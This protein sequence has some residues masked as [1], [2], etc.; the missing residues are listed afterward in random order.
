M[1]LLTEC[2]ALVLQP[3]LLYVTVYPVLMYTFN[4]YCSATL[5]A[6][7]DFCFQ[8][9]MCT[10]HRKCCPQIASNSTV[11]AAANSANLSLSVMA[12]NCSTQEG[13]R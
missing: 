13:F 10:A 7:V 4:S 9:I 5:M 2:H 3:L 6:I 12:G 1:L 8:Y 11:T